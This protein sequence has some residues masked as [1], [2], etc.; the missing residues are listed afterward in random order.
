MCAH[1]FNQTVEVERASLA[2][3]FTAALEDGE[4]GDAADVELCGDGWF[5]F[6][7][8]FG[9]THGWFKLLCGLSENRG[10]VPA[11]AAPRGPEVNHERTVATLHV[12]REICA[13]QFE[14][15]TQK[16]GLF[17]FSAVRRST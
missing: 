6:G 10:H 9:Q 5:C 15:M 17:A 7:V 2:D 13:G 3:L 4:G 14:G 1:P 12:L 11:R 16:Q 8:E